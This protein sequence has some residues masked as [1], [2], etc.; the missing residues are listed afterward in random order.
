MDTEHPNS[1][2]IVTNPKNDATDITRVGAARL[3]IP[4]ATHTNVSSAGAPIQQ[5]T[6]PAVDSD[7]ITLSTGSIK[8]KA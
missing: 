6:V 5:C 8:A 1:F 4:V 3:L 2:N 7:H